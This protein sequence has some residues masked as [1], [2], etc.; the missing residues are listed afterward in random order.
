MSNPNS[1]ASPK[2][3][4]EHLGLIGGAENGMLDADFSDA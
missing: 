2:C 3:F 4:F 1:A